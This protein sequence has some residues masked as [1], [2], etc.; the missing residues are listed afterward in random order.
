MP[1]SQK[2]H[3][4]EELQNAASLR[5]QGWSFRRIHDETGIPRSTLHDHLQG[6]YKGFDTAFGRERTLTDEE[7]ASIINYL[8]YM[9]GR[10][11]P[12]NRK[13]L[14]VLMFEVLK[15]RPRPTAINL[16]KGPSDR[17]V[18]NF[19]KRHGDVLTLRQSHSL[20]SCRAEVHQG[21]VDHFYGLLDNMM[22]SLGLKFSPDSIYNM[23]ESGFSGRLV[24]SKRVIMPKGARH[25]YQ[26]QVSLSGH[27]T[28]VQ[29]I[30]ASGRTVPPMVIFSGC[31]PRGDFKAGIPDDWVFKSTDSGFVNTEMFIQWFIDIFLP[32]VGQKRPVLLL[33]DNL[34]CHWNPAFLDLAQENKIDLLFFPSHASHLLQ[35]LDV[36]YFHLLKQ[37]VADLAVSLGYL[38]CKTLP[39]LTFPKLLHQAMNQINGASVAASFADTGIYPFNNKAVK[40]LQPTPKENLADVPQPDNICTQCGHST[41]NQL[42]KLGLVS[43]ELANILVEPPLPQKKEKGKR[44]NHEYAEAVAS[45]STS[46]GT[47]ERKDKKQKTNK[48]TVLVPEA[49]STN[50]EDPSTETLCEVCMTSGLP[51]YFW[52]GCDTC[53]RWFH[54]E[55]LPAAIQTDVDI[56]LVLQ[57]KK[58]S[59]NVCQAEE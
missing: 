44:K 25:A 4:K 23:D 51:E 42:V 29:A 6:K 32:T 54:Y 12:L 3:S 55:C 47:C 15:R 36:V 30:S 5:S 27:T 7:E 33:L 11:F 19:L 28:V 39:R 56:S 31:M 35:P 14:Q 1:R 9:A 24:S 40:A 20:E 50:V 16:E 34:S 43:K 59:C 26:S 21:Q 18:T 17:F 41:E 58:F 8:Q 48:V 37:K 22:R 46:T 52:V 49:E 13:N 53:P 10:G 45:T 57:D 2:I 38:G